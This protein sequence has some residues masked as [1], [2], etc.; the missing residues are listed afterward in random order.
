MREK[1]D[2]IGKEVSLGLGRGNG[3]VIGQTKLIETR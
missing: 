3:S 1:D 2:V